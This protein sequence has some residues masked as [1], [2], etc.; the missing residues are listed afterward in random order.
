MVRP[1]NEI[2]IRAPCDIRFKVHKMRAVSSFYVKLKVRV[3]KAQ[4]VTG[5]R[6]QY[7]KDLGSVSDLDQG[8]ASSNLISSPSSSVRF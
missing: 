6:D 5:I 4:S 8:L 7:V 1:Q 2:W 3:I